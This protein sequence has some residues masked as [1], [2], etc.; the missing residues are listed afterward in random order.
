MPYVFLGIFFFSGFA[1]LLY[2]T[3]WQRM[4]TLFGGTDVYSVTI[5]VAAF[6]AGLGIGNLT[7]GHIADRL[8][9]RARLAAFV[10]CEMAIAAFA[11]V[12]ATLYYDVLYGWLGPRDLPR[13]AL[14]AIVFL[15]TLWPTFFMGMSLP[16][17]SRVLTDDA[18]EPAS[19]VPRLYG[20]NTAGAACGALFTVAVIFRTMGFRDGLLVGALISLC[21]G[22]AAL[23]W[24]PAL[25]RAQAADGAAD[26]VSTGR[27][28]SAAPPAPP[29]G[30]TLDNWVAVYALS[31]F[32]ALSLEIVWFRVLGVAIKS[33]AYTF[34]H[35]LAIY[36]AGVG[37]GSLIANTHW[38]KRLSPVP[39]FFLL[40]TAVPIWAGLSASLLLQG[41]GRVEWLDPLWTY[42]GSYDFLGFA[43]FRQPLFYV[44]YGLL[45]LALIGPSTLCMGMSFA[46]LQRAVQTDV[47]V[48]GRRVGWLQTA[49][50]AGSLAGALLTGVLL[51]DRLGSP[52][53]LRLLA[54]A[55]VV[56]IWLYARGQRRWGVAGAMTA[57]AVL[58]TIGVPGRD[59]FWARLHGATEDAVIHGED[60]S[61]LSVLR[62]D[63]TGDATTVFVNGLGQSW[64]PFGGIHTAL[65]ALPALLHPN[66][67]RIAI[68]GLGSGD[69]VF[70]A[71]GREETRTIDAIEIIK[72]Q[73]DTLRLLRFQGDYSGL[74]RL[75]TDARINYHFTDG[76]TFLQRSRE[77]YDIIEAD[78]LRPNSAY[79]GNLYSVE[80][81]ALLRDRLRP[82]GLAVSWS[83]TRRV[84]F[85]MLHEFP[86]VADFGTVVIGSKSPITVDRATVEARMRSTFT[87]LYYAAGGIRIEELMASYLSRQP[88]LIGPG[89]ARGELNVN[90]DLFPKDEFSIPRERR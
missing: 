52:G 17:A 25:R 4:L 62:R 26:P 42:F 14:A 35:L 85:G 70:G 39:T 7:G 87:N 12:S 75:L 56:F 15:V 23:A 30:L 22:L 51:L 19:W 16:L 64:L 80:Y 45:P 76:R 79:A 84:F 27:P 78:A 49:N 82:D 68:I 48:L 86:Y 83:P 53:T 47:R 67:E 20:W 73:L 9:G 33:S 8:S 2:Q 6:M 38:F 31:G 66:P 40:Q 63:N 65:G 37:L 41:V 60:A 74:D 32:V 10:L 28:V 55:S 29:S 69:T 50:I 46:F 18:S 88:A 5:V 3:I 13:A 72:P 43:Q 58:V 44:V 61:G 21:C 77:P 89:D 59:V 36:L 1:A 71:G 81:F 24:W 90:Y 54:A 11:V 34:G 57:A